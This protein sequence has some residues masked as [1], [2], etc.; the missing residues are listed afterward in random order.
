MKSRPIAILTMLLAISLSVFSQPE[1]KIEINKDIYLYQIQ[2]SIFVHVTYENSNEWGRFSSNGLIF[3]KNGE[4][5]MIDTPMD[6][7][8][9]EAI[10]HFLANSFNVKL[11]KLII[12]HF[13]NDCL[14]GLPYIQSQGIESIANILTVEKCKE[15][16]LAIPSISFSDSLIIDFHGEKV[17]CR[18]SGG[19]HSNDNITVWLPNQKV[20]FGGCLIRSTQNQNLGNLSDA[21][22]TQWAQTVKRVVS[23]CPNVQIVI[24][25]HGRWGGNELLFHTIQLAEKYQ[26]EN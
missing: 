10:H 23:Q 18:Y 12:G 16:G 1:N 7:E 25:G 15:L 22:V 11:T 3:I 9:T 20:L 6:N 4:A 2:D 5:I 24:P 8:K 21:V 26:A 19:G 14:G 17:V 13:H